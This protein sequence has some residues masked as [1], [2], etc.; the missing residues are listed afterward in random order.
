M[1][2]GEKT[3]MLLRKEMDFLGIREVEGFDTSEDGWAFILEYPSDSLP[4]INN[5]LLKNI[6]K[7]FRDKAYQKIISLHPYLVE[8]EL[9]IPKRFK[10]SLKYDFILFEVKNHKINKYKTYEIQGDGHFDYVFGLKAFCETIL[11]DVIKENFGTVMIPFHKGIMKDV[12]L[13][14]FLKKE[15][16]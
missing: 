9:I 16:M 10:D 7:N 11:S 15:I 2:P 6:P 1:R 3:L 5:S 14:D 4:L 13:R 8:E 12:Y